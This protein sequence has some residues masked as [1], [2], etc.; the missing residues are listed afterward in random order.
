MTLN[1]LEDRLES[2]IRHINTAI[3]VDPWA[4]ELAVESMRM[5]KNKQLHPAQCWGC[6]CPKME[7]QEII[8]CRD[9]KNREKKADWFW[10]EEH[11]IS[12]WKCK[13]GH[14]KG[15]TDSVDMNDFCSF[16]ERRT[17]AD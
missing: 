6:N 10:C 13:T 17:D 5:R 12:I 11:G 16:A 14:G 1:S 8:H 4:R 9:C 3:D 7:R 2:A 15:A